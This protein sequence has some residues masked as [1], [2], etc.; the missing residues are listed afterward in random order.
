MEHYNER[1]IIPEISRELLEQELTSE[2]FVGKTNNGGNLLYI[3]SGADAPHLM[4]EVGRLREIAFRHAGGGTGEEVDIDHFDT[5]EN[6]YQQLIV[7]DP[8]SKEILGGYRYKICDENTIDK[9]G[10]I[11]LSTAELFNFSKKFQEEYLPNMIELGRSFVQPSY[12][13]TRRIR[14]GIYALDNLWDGLGAILVKNPEKK[15]FFGKVTM[16]T[17]YNVQARNY[18]LYFLDKYFADT[19]MLITPI[20]PMEMN[21]NFDEM[22]RVFE[23]N[24]YAEDYKILKK[25]VRSLG[26]IIP[27]LINSYMDLSATMKVFGTAI[28]PHFGG[29]EETAILVTIL[30]IYKEKVDRH[31]ISFDPKYW[32]NRLKHTHITIKR[33]HIHLLPRRKRHDLT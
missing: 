16:Y 19:D 27:P 17:S 13:S 7:W 31:I 10:N 15:Y 12:Q 24:H 11:Q 1:E 4:R 20:I 32:I 25:S 18:L 8:D 2:R 23:G 14:K 33:P 22:N 28:N 21:M 9:D 3:F 5:C 30:D 6:C 29:V 26:E